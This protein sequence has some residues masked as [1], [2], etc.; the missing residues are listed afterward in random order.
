MN[1]RSDRTAPRFHKSNRIA[2]CCFLQTRKG[3]VTGISFIDSTPIEVCCP[4]RSRSHRVFEGLVGWGK[5]SVGWHYGFKLHLIINDKG[6]LLAFKL[7]PGNTDDR[8][9]V[10]DMTQDIIGK[11]F[12]DRGYISQELF[13]KLY[14]QGLIPSCNLKRNFRAL[15]LVE[16]NAYQSRN[17]Q[18]KKLTSKLRL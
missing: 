9:P 6:E 15:Y 4:S 5:N 14:E 13:E 10:P 16:Q 1:N 18:I 3:E 8:K 2:I 11:L 17:P 12:G 7:T